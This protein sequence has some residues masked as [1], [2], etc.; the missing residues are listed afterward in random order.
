M[1]GI[2]PVHGITKSQT[3]ISNQTTTKITNYNKEHWRLHP[4]PTPC[5]QVW[6]CDSAPAD[7][8][9]VEAMPA[10]PGH[11]LSSEAPTSS[12][13][14]PFLPFHTDWNAGD[15]ATRQKEPGFPVNPQSRGVLPAQNLTQPD[16]SMR[17]FFLKALHFLDG[18]R[19][20]HIKWNKSDRERHGTTWHH[21][22]SRIYGNSKMIQK[23]FFTKQKHTHR[24]RKQT[25]GYWRGKV[26]GVN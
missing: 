21:M 17:S 10:P 9:W 4:S 23:N 8:K 15:G 12:V 20:D 18:P 24:H 26:R 16:Q 22:I 5:S 19:D 25:Y 1:H 14:D 11:V 7:M 13:L 6:L 2:T 3:Q